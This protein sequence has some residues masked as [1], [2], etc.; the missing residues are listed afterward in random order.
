MNFIARASATA[1]LTG[2]LLAGCSAGEQPA[3]AAA[4]TGATP[5]P[6][7]GPSRGAS[8]NTQPKPARTP[9]RLT[10][11]TAPA[12]PTATPPATATSAPSRPASRAATTPP[13]HTVSPT[14]PRPRYSATPYR[15]Q[16]TPAWHSR[17]RH[18]PGH[19]WDDDDIWPD[20]TGDCVPPTVTVTVQE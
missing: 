2:S 18:D 14:Q 20:S 16:P 4:Q 11:T 7:A 6:A 12:R 8:T 3:C 17:H 19:D 10:P 9:P 5:A 1:A 13:G 15:G